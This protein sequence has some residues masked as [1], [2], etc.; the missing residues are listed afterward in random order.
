MTQFTLSPIDQAKSIAH[1]VR[2]RWERAITGL[3]LMLF[4][5][6]TASAS[7]LAA[8]ICKVFKQLF[9]NDLVAIAAGIG[10]AGLLIANAMDEGDNKLK[11]GALRIGAA[12]AALVNLE[13]ISA[14]VTGT[15]WGC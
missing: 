9:G 13:T 12:A 1:I 15:P 8:P 3:M 4:V 14:M 10:G 11:T 7:L 6:N 2:S 5:A